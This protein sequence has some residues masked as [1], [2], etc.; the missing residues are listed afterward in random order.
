MKK[1]LLWLCSVCFL[2]IAVLAQSVPDTV[3][4]TVKG[5]SI[6]TNTVLNPSL[7]ILIKTSLTK[8]VITGDY[9]GSTYLP[10]LHID[11]QG[12][13]PKCDLS[14][15]IGK[16]GNNIVIKLTNLTEETITRIGGKDKNL[17]IIF[18][19]DLMFKYQIDTSARDKAGKRVYTYGRINKDSLNN[20]LSDQLSFTAA[21][22]KNFLSSVNTMYY[23]KNSADFGVQP[24]KDSSSFALTLSFNYQNLYSSNSLLKCNNGSN[25]HGNTLIY[26]NIATR[27]S[28][29]FKDSL[30]F[31]NIYPLVIQGSN[32][33][34]SLIKEWA[35]K[36]GHESSQD[37]TFRRVALDASLSAI[38]SNLI[39]LASDNSARL[40][41]KPII[42]LGIKGY[43]D[44]SKAN[45]AFTS[46]QAYVTGYYYIPVYDHYAIII[47]DKTFY[48]FSLKNNPKKLLAS[49][50]SI[51]I[52]TEL[53]K[54]DFKVMLKY[55]NGKSE[56]NQ[57]ETQAVV[58]GMI[59]N[60][61]TDKVK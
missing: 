36:A 47:N 10:A 48:D 61:F 49:N 33:K 6:D 58:I 3:V 51:A 29:N 50:Y 39:D 31:I 21:D 30:N 27:L 35:F 44:Y 41:L 2:P 14:Y 43:H 57:K 22:Q 23:Y 53:P 34:S 15:N 18:D 7:S 11:Y 24:S 13:K 40:R 28:S 56:F 37:F 12:K 5:L 8:G 60:L 26:Y 38:I 1:I 54:T 32:Y 17:K 19:K 20:A 55:Q 46:G 52:G 4:H 25:K 45:T 9:Y 42:G 16:K 59:M